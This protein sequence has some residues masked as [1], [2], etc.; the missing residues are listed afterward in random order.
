MADFTAQ[1]VREFSSARVKSLN[2]EELRA[3][4]AALLA[5][6]PGSNE[7]ALLRIESKIDEMKTSF[8]DELNTKITL[9][10]SEQNEK[11]NDLKKENLELRECLMQHQR[12]LESLESQKRA[13]N[14]LIFGASES[15]ITDGDIVCT[16]DLEKTKLFFKKIDV[17]ADIVSV[18]RLGKPL[19]QGSTKKRPIKVQLAPGTNRADILEKAKSLKD[20]DTE[21]YNT[22][23]IK[24]DQH[25]LIRKELAR[26]YNVVKT[27]KEK[28]VNQTKLVEFNK[29]TRCVT[30]DGVVI[31]RFKIQFF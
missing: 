8:S 24:K 4:V 29:D 13:D 21:P 14:V 15:N 1:Q 31:D 12:F 6:P 19:E 30:V 5:E 7:E 3:A 17:Q 2:K 23:Y 11:M 9:L 10:K 28:P 16:T 18:S 26:L 20:E 22:V 27:E 25:P